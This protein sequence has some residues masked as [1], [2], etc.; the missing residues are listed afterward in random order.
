MCLCLSTLFWCLL[1]SESLQNTFLLTLDF[2]FICKFYYRIFSELRKAP[3]SLL[4]IARS[5]S[6][7]YLQWQ[8]ITYMANTMFTFNV[9]EIHCQII[10]ITLWFSFLFLC[11]SRRR[12]L[13]ITS[14]YMLT[15]LENYFNILREEIKR[16]VTDINKWLRIKDY[17][18][19]GSD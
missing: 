2:C 12:S 8:H 18:I 9:W 14:L 19:Y 11:K 17:V 5:K 7:L 1:F 10:K 3:F 13:S 15:P 16:E 6:F 4:L